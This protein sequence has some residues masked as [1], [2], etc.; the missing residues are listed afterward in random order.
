MIKS[1]IFDLGGVY[2]TNGARIAIGKISHKFS[3][4]PEFVGKALEFNSEL[5]MLY[6]KGEITAEEFWDKAK[7]LLGINA[8]NNYL[9]KIWVDSYKPIQGTIKIIKQL[10]K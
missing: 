1:I 10:K 8:D 6:R 9:N 5:G 2:F 3:L 4:H 7:K